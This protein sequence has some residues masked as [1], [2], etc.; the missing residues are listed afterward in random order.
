MREERDLRFT[1]IDDAGAIDM[2]LQ[3]IQRLLT[4]LVGVRLGLSCVGLRFWRGELPRIQGNHLPRFSHATFFGF[5]H[6]LNERVILRCY[7]H[8]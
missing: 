6:V 1:Q 3:S 8:I 7:R 5:P 2:V 4:Y